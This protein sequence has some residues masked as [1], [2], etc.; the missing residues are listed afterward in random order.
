[1]KITKKN[2]YINNKCRFCD[3]KKGNL[4][5]NCYHGFQEFTGQIDLRIKYKKWTKKDQKNW[6]KPIA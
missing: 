1:M 4:H 5:Y 2:L 3:V 6:I